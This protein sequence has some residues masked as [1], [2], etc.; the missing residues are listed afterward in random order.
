VGKAESQ[1][2]KEIKRR[3]D[4]RGLSQEELAHRAEVHSSYISQL[5]RGVKSP[6]LG[7][8]CR[9]AKALEV[10]PSVIVSAVDDSTRAK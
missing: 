8:I 5:E 1:F 4:A 6:T 2:G 7:V 10:Q 9:L 3:R